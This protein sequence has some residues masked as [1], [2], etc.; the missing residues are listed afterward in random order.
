[1]GYT[2]LSP[3]SF[4]LLLSL[5]PLPNSIRPSCKMKSL[6]KLGRVTSTTTG[7]ASIRLNTELG[8]NLC[9]SPQFAC[10]L[11]CRSNEY[12]MYNTTA[13][14]PGFLG[15][16]RIFEKWKNRTPVRSEPRPFIGR[17]IPGPNCSV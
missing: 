16:V 8:N 5:L 14:N 15:S 1:M 4:V 11:E 9:T 13:S 12:P 3:Q 17:L 10:R 2:L 7:D 6:T